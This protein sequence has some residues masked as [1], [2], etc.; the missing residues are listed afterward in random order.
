MIDVAVFTFDETRALKFVNHAGARLLAQPGERLL[1]RSAIEIG[2]ADCLE[3]AIA[4][5][6]LPKDT[7]PQHLAKLLITCWEGA[8]LRCRLA[9]D[10]APLRDM[11]QFYFGAVSP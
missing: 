2:L 4:R 5:G 6:E 7:K 10:P 11:L 1:G 3:E 8:A 9:R